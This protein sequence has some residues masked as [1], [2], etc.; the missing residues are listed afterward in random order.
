MPAKSSGLL[1]TASSCG[2]SKEPWPEPGRCDGGGSRTGAWPDSYGF[3]HPATVAK[4]ERRFISLTGA[5]SDW[6]L[7][8]LGVPCA[9]AGA[10]QASQRLDD[11]GTISDRRPAAGK[12]LPWSLRSPSSGLAREPS[13]R[14]G[15]LECD[16]ASWARQF[17][18]RCGV[19][20][21]ACVAA[22]S[23]PRIRRI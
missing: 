22:A 21:G 16:V 13:R 1:C 7:A 15:R 2:L 19:A 17:L 5:D 12:P 11:K 10:G 23:A 9:Y 18:H 6:N 14:V 3:H 20:G 4:G 8:D